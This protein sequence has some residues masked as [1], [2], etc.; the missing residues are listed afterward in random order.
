MGQSILVVGA[1]AIGAIAG[2]HLIEQ[3]HTVDLVDANAAHVA[4]VRA[5]GLR[6]S[7]V[8]DVTVPANIMLPEDVSGRYDIILLAVKAPHTASTLDMVKRVLAAD[9]CVV[10]LQNG[11][12]EYRIADAVGAD[13]TIGGYLTFGGFFVEPGHI[14]NGGS[15]SFKIGEVDGQITD[16][17]KELGELLAPVHKVD[18]TDNI[19][20]YLWAKMALGAVYFG[21][22]IADM[23]V[24]DVYQRPKARAVLAK[25]CAEVTAV[26]DAKGI[27]IENSD[28]FDPKAFRAG[29]TDS[30]MQA[31]WDAQTRYWNSHDNRRT[32]VWRDL[33]TFKR[34]TEV[35][36]QVLPVIE[37]GEQLGV[38]T[39]WLR[40][41]RN[42]VKAV[43]AGDAELGIALLEALEG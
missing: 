19:F 27:R 9:G 6:L 35:D 7:G 17:I 28:G 42:A 8:R 3:G 36:F 39:P 33:A 22:A 29:G 15:G 5:N 41:L 11:L 32:G 4:A 16:R 31:S 38:P 37:I 14:K 30:E 2:V 12:E 18:I 26:A 20:G 40:A 43:E 21:T 1:G 34:P 24:V 10:S 13:R 23:D 25:I